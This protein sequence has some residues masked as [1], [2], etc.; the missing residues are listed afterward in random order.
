[1]REHV[2]AVAVVHG[3]QVVLVVGGHWL[4]PQPTA[5]GACTQGH[6]IT[7]RAIAAKSGVTLSPRSHVPH[8]RHGGAVLAAF[9][10]A[11]LPADKPHVPF[12]RA[13]RRSTG[14][15]VLAAVA[16]GAGGPPM[17]GIHP[18]DRRL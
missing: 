3:Q 11:C 5:I 13:F 12:P 9:P 1:G 15:P 8:G 16:A 4:P 10:V 18:T 7:S 2:E 17:P 6:A 14:V